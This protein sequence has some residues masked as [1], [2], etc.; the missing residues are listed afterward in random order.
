ME[1]SYIDD[2]L[3][4]AELVIERTEN[5]NATGEY[6]GNDPRLYGHGT[7]EVLRLLAYKVKQ[8]LEMQQ[9]NI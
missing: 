3:L 2:A 9:W 1:K 5:G 8:Q 7:D 6:E 4:L